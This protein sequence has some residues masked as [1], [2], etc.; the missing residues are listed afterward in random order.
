MKRHLATISMALAV[1]ASCTKGP[2]PVVV[3][4]KH[5]KVEFENDRVRVLHVTIGP[6]EK[7]PMHYHPDYIII[8]LTADRGRAIDPD[9]RVTEGDNV[10]GASAGNALFH[11][12]ENLSDTPM[13]RYIVEFKRR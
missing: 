9:G 10:K 6:H 1:L 12:E 11:S 7:T 4:P 2:D 3:D 8:A 13:E 5:Y